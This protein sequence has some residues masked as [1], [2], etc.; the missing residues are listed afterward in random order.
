MPPKKSVKKKTRQDK[1]VPRIVK[2]EMP[3]EYGGPV[4]KCK[5]SKQ[6]KINQRDFI[7]IFV[8]F[9]LS[10]L[11]VLCAIGLVVRLTHG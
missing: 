7:A 1:I 4:V 2:V 10:C 6:T 8:C 5:I 9:V 3:K 11:S